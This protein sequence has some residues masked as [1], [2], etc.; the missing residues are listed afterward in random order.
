MNSIAKV[1]QP[2]STPPETGSGSG[3]MKKSA[4]ATGQQASD[5]GSCRTACGLRARV[6]RAY[7]LPAPAILY[8]SMVAL[9]GCATCGELNSLRAEVARANAA[10]VLAEERLAR[11][12]RQLTAFQESARPPPAA[13]R[14]LS[15]EP[16]REVASRDELP[17]ITTS[18]QISGYKWGTL[19]QNAAQAA[20][21]RRRV[22]ISS[23]QTRLSARLPGPRGSGGLVCGNKAVLPG[24]AIVQEKIPESLVVDYTYTEGWP[25]IARLNRADE[26]SL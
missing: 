26:V 12:Q 19:R 13:E 2:R 14:P 11:A 24:V 17:A 6:L 1:S 10:A 16:R 15:A 8:A 23:A 3:V 22:R 18:S 21:W 25:K 20:Q 5:S 4:Y 7:N 9:T